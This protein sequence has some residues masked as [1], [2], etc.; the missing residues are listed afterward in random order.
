[1]AL[2]NA[3]PSLE[4]YH[5]EFLE[6]VREIRERESLTR[7]AKARKMIEGLK[8]ERK[9]L[10]KPSPRDPILVS[11][12]MKHLPPTASYLVPKKESDV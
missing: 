11:S 12:K 3:T 1:M 7:D 5:E 6:K 2:T 9:R 8:E 10:N 4:K